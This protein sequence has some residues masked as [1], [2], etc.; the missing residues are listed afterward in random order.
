[1]ARVFAGP[2]ELAGVAASAFGSGRRLAGVE[3]LRG[4]TKKGVYRLS[5]DDGTSVIGYVWGAAENY[6][7]G[8]GRPDTGADP[9]ADASGAGLFE[10]AHPEQTGLGVRTPPV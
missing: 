3:R 2:Q 4:G 7:P 5:F 1:M 8:A 10:A 9:F 6:W